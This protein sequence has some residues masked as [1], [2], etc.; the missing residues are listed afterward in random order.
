MAEPS[1]MTQ[2]L[3]STK[4]LVKNKKKK[5]GYFTPKLFKTSSNICVRYPCHTSQ[6]YGATPPQQFCSHSILSMGGD[7]P[8]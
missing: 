6:D 2:E 3:S 5:T 8:F 4:L 1:N 7:E